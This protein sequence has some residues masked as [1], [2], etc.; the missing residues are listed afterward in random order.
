[1]RLDVAW[2]GI[3]SV[4]GQQKPPVRIQVNPARLTGFGL[5]LEDVRAA[6]VSTMTNSPKGS[7]RGRTHTFTLHDNDQLLSAAPWNDAVIA[8]RDHGPV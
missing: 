5:S 6:I 2:V 8:F 4:L 7:I 3:V 1:V